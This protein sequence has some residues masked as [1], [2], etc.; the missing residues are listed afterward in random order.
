MNDKM[1]A[2]LFGGM[3]R[4]KVLQHLFEH[5]EQTFSAR[6]LA[7]ATAL[8]PGNVHRLL[9]KWEQV[10]LVRRAQKTGFR[11]TD[12]PALNLLGALLRQN[13]ELVNDLREVLRDQPGVESAFVFGSYAR[14]EEKASSDIDVL[15][16]GAV[17]ELKTN[18]ALRPLS[19]KYGRPFHA[20]AF[21]KEQ[22]HQLIL[23]EDPF[24]LDVQKSPRISII[25]HLDGTT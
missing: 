13:T 1:F 12:D 5:P 21:T 14:N 20:S 19:R 9:Q 3:G 10:G 11:V 7:A 18:A 4:F 15:V 22:F 6:E 17:S 16:L 8:D 25:G 24:A 23:D 2:E